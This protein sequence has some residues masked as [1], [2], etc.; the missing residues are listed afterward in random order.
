MKTTRI[1][2]LESEERVRVMVVGV[3]LASIVVV[4]VISRSG[5]RGDKEMKTKS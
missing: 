4:D 1:G 2:T 5:I 3:I